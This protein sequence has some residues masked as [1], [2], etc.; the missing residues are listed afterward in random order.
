M[1]KI[2]F[3]CLSI[4]LVTGCATNRGV[5]DITTEPSV[6]AAST[7]HKG[8][9]KFASVIDKRE[10]Q[11]N[12]R[13]ANIPSLKDNKINDSYITE[14]AIAR[15]RNGYGKAL[16]D[17]VLPDGATV[18]QLVE[19]LLTHEFTR[20]GYHVA[21]PGDQE[22][23]QA[24]PFDVE[25]NKFWGWFNPGFW[26]ISISFETDVLV[27]AP[28]D[29]FVEGQRFSSYMQKNYQVASGKNWKE[30]IDLSLEALEH[31]VRKKVNLF[32]VDK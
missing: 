25:V 15:K 14:R 17:I 23:E 27:L 8:V 30:V 4:I 21:K 18:P 7:G 20:H 26:S 13:Q 1:K 16:G 22:Y 10:F 31:D 2:V 24:I 29:P 19:Q 5:L 3:L 11:I 28:V 9:I 12:P 6:A 32:D